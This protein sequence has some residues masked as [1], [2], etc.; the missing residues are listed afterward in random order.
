MK[1]VLGIDLGGTKILIGELTLE[2]Q[3]LQSKRYPSIVTSQREAID[4]VKKSLKDFLETTKS[5]GDIQAIGIGLVGRIDRDN[6]IWIEIHPEL[7]KKID[8]ANE[9]KETFGLPCYLG[10]DV[11][12]ATLAEQTY[13]IGQLTKHFIY[14]NIGTGIAARCVVDGKILEGANFDAGEI[15]HMVVD[16]DSKIPCLCGRSGCVE[17]LA[18]GL[19]MHNRAIALLEQ[20]PDSC[21]KVSQSRRITAKQLFNG[22]DQNDPLCKEI[23][24]TALKAV[25]TTLMNLI[26]VTDPTAIILGGGV[27]DEWFIHHL[28]TYMNQKTIRFIRHGISK[29][30]L[31]AKTL[32]LRGAALLA[33]NN[34]ER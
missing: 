7:S 30:A 20:Y 8:V 9:I 11:Y 4:T 34:I 2:G 15:G 26:R 19:G 29:T 17:V 24:D 31:E 1:T 27:V 12:C 21:I 28:S 18:S 16:F 6:G 10:N 3:V 23:V 32:G 14:M 13:G 5:Y 25:A 22:Y 33:S